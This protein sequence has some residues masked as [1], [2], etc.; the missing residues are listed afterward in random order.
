M[1][2]PLSANDNYFATR[3]CHPQWR[4]V[5]S[6]LFDK[7]LQSVPQAE[8]R[9]FLHQ[10]GANLALDL[11]LGAQD[12]L[13]TLQAA[14]NKRWA[15]LDW[16]FVTLTSTDQNLEIRHHHC[17]VPYHQGRVSDAAKQSLAMMLEGVYT[18]WLMA[19]GGEPDVQAQ[20]VSQNDDVVLHYGKQNQDA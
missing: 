16:G 17:P 5:L 19:Q 6:A 9:L 2:D 12:T 15:E 3:H 18:S 11:P 7:L 4:L 14:I 13:D 1:T 10:V 8:A 20:C